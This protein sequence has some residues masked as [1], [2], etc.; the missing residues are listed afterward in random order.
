[1]CRL[2]IQ[3]TSRSFTVIF[4]KN[5]FENE[6]AHEIGLSFILKSICLRAVRNVSPPA[7]YLSA[8]I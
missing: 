1:V 2:P 5:P 8:R 6:I 7:L 4:K 3:G